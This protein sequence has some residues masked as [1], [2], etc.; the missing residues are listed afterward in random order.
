[1]RSSSAGLMPSPTSPMKQGWSAGNSIWRRN[2]TAVG[3]GV[4]LREIGELLHRLGIPARAAQDRHRRLGLRQHL[5]QLVHLAGGRRGVDHLIA[6]RIGH[7]GGFDQDVLG[8][9]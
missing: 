8:Q 7:A 9:R 5:R 3:K 2:D 1:M 4:A 6:R